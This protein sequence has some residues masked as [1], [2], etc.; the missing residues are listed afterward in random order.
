MADL[1]NNIPDKLTNQD[2]QAE[3]I[4]DLKLDEIVADYKRGRIEAIYQEVKLWKI[5][6]VIAVL[7]LLHGLYVLYWKVTV[8]IF[9]LN[10]YL[11]LAGVLYLLS[12]IKS[13]IERL[14]PSYI[15]SQKKRIYEIDR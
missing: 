15:E 1:L 12:I 4:R 3:S 5:C 14:Q 2:N 13:F 11:I 10:F 8:K 7:F 6:S 9:D